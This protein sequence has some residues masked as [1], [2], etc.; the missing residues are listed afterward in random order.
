MKSIKTA[1]STLILTALATALLST[2]SAYAQTAPT[3]DATVTA[4]TAPSAPATTTGDLTLRLGGFT[5]GGIGTATFGGIL[6]YHLMGW[7]QHAPNAEPT[8]RIKQ[9]VGVGDF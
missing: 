6:L 5:L 1:S 8:E 7:R 3:T 9:S 4:T 2:G